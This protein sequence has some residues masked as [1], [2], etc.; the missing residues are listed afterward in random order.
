MSPDARPAP[1]LRTLAEVD[2][3]TERAEALLARYRLELAEL[4][5][6]GETTVRARMTE[7]QRFL[8]LVGELPRDEALQSK[9]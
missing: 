1:R 6:E 8:L 3:A 2:A 5:A 4:E 9:G 7:R